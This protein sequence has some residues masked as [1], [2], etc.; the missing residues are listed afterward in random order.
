MDPVTV[1][2]RFQK[3]LDCIRK[4]MLCKTYKWNFEA[5]I[6][7]YLVYVNITSRKAQDKEYLLRIK[8]DDYPQRAPSYIFVDKTTKEEK[9]DAW[10]PRIRHPG[11]PPGICTPGTRE[12]HENLHKKDARYQWDAEK[13]NIGNTLMQLQ[14]LV[15]KPK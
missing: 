6:D 1:K 13:Y 3:E 7:E 9:N 12:F 4:G 10:P 14:L 8:F 15:D 11:P 2:E 5:N